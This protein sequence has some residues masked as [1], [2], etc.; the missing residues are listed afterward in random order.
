MGILIDGKKA[1]Q[2]SKNETLA[3]IGRNRNPSISDDVANEDTLAKKIAQEVQSINSRS[4][5][6]GDS[7]EAC[8][9]ICGHVEYLEEIVI[10][11]SE[12]FVTTEKTKRKIIKK[13]IS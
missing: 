2:S 5:G 7:N 6:A 3:N 9:S 8:S 11:D 13:L 12:S 1:L 10:P 4:V